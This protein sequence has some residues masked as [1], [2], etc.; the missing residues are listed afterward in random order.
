MIFLGDYIAIGLVIVMSM[1]YFDSKKGWRY[2]PTA[3]KYYVGCLM[4]TALTAATDI[5]TGHLMWIP[6]VPLWIHVTMNTAYFLVNIVTTSTFA[7]YLFTKILEHAHDN[8]C[9]ILARRFLSVLFGLYIILV[10]AN[11]WTGVL[12]YFDEQGAYCR[13]PLNAAGYAVT[14]LQM[15]LVTMC[16]FRNRKN[17]SKPM[18]RA[19]LQTFPV[20]VLCIMIQRAFPETMLNAFVMSMV[21]LVLFLT[22]QGQ[23]QGVHSLTELNDRRRFFNEIERRIVRRTP[24]RVFLINIK[25]FGNIN[26]KYGHIFGD[27]LLYQ[28]A[29]SLEKLFKES[30]AFHMNG[31]VF[32]LMLPAAVQ[33]VAEEQCGVLIDFLERKIVCRNEQVAI[34][35]VLV[36]Y[37]ADG[38]ETSAAEFYEKLEYAA[39]N[40]YREKHS[41]TRY[42]PEMGAKME[43]D[44]YLQERLQTV[45]R[46]KGYEVWYQPVKCLS[47]GK[48]CSME[49]LIRLREE[50]GSLISP[51]EFIPLAEQTGRITSVTWFV[52]DEVCRLLGSM[53]ELRG[54]SVSVN[55]PMPQLLERG[56]VTRLNSIVDRAGVPH[57]SICLEFT[58]RA[59]LE[60][61]EKTKDV[62]EQLTRD[63][64]RF[65]LDDFGT[66]YSNFNCLLQLPFQIIKLDACLVKQH[67]GGSRS[68]DMVRT[69]TKMFHDMNLQVIAEG[70]ETEAEVQR[71]EEQGVDRVQGFALSRPM[72]EDAL[73]KFYRENPVEEPKSR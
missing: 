20:I 12:F 5:I 24:F 64:Y 46:S 35:Y 6:G 48:F 22:F 27:E 73:L 29:F 8:H 42:T 4:L 50:D 31:T 54:V 71:L 15:C 68:Y 44:R 70:A 53:P 10:G 63:G 26:Q 72:P 60:N 67:E 34:D 18:R 13:G 56:F 43:R 61:F 16:Y 69:L 32:A 36:E 23:R 49:A 21:A 11:L 65:F 59:I 41:Y 7:L 33:T 19:L 38:S 1:F 58:E 2:L 45:E 3:S 52:L 28:F 55:M 37:T 51:A 9:M 47:T 57:R 40:A 25:N 17:A 30:M 62:M 14:I 39:A 66:G